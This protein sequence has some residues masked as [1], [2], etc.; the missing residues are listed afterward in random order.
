MLQDVKKSRWGSRMIHQ[1]NRRLDSNEI[2]NTETLGPSPL[3]AISAGKDN[4]L[5][6]AT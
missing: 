2:M 1:S 6:I 5:L 4:Q 3:Q